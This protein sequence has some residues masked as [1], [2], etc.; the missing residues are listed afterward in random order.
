MGPY[1]TPAGHP[2]D[3]DCLHFGVHQF[4]GQR[5]G[6]ALIVT[7]AVHG[8]EVC[9]PIGIERVMA[10]IGA[11]RLRILAGS[12][13]FVPVTNPLAYARGQRN[14]DRNLN[15]NLF[16]TASPQDFEDR[17]ANWLCPLLAQ[18]DV[19]LDCHSTHAQNPAFATLGPRN[20]SGRL[21]PFAREAQER[22]LIKHL[23]VSRFV[24]GWLDAYA[25]GVARRADRLASGGVGGGDAR[26]AALN[27]DVRYGVGTTE[28]MRQTG[29]YAITLECGSHLDPESPNV[30]YRAICNA[31]AHLGISNGPKPEPVS[32]CEALC[33]VD[34]I[35]R[36]SPEDRFS[37]AWASFDVLSAGD[38][39]GTRASGEPVH[40]P[41]N[42]R[43]LFPDANA[44]PG[45][46]WFY[47]TENRDGI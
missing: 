29:G 13:S 8:N 22:A 44:Q 17:I 31:L 46:E 15:R 1:F 37:R 3:A 11:G 38:L 27:T 42:G 21:Q 12:V 10:D 28:Y 23:G 25:K 24:E 40:A 39:I 26:S 9:G 5:P 36:L 7:G 43:I 18:H 16:P 4:T 32:H 14:G 6:P 33:I 35:D 19:L 20:N 34:V 2:I 47:L 30:A 45:N 41:A